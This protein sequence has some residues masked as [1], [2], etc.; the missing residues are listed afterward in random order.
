MRNTFL[1][2]ILILECVR[3][4]L[5]WGIAVHQPNPSVT[6][7]KYMIQ[8]LPLY[9]GLALQ[10]SLAV[11]I[12]FG[13]AKISRSRELDALHALGFS[14]VQLLTPII[15][16]T[17]AVIASSLIILGWLQP[18]SLY[19]SKVFVHD[20]EQ[21]S[22]LISDGADLFRVD[23]AKTL[24]LDGVSRD[25]KL[26]DR[27]FI[28]ETYPDQKS[29]TTTGTNGNIYGQGNLV[30]QQYFVNA[31]DL[32][33]VKRDALG[34]LASASTS[35]RSINVQGPL[36]D[37]GIKA[38]RPRGESEYEWTLSE[39]FS[40]GSNLAAS[41]NPKRLNAE[42]NYRLA[43]LLFIL[44]LPLIAVAAVIEPRRNPGPLRFLIGLLVVLGANQ[45]LGLATSFSRDDI[46]PPVLTLWIPLLL[47]AGV[48]FFRFWQIAY[49]PAFQGAR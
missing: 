6:I 18:L 15:A 8:W 16:L 20:I 24:M 49:K 22:A 9:I 26:F 27:V 30:S 46:L 14:L 37:I 1:Y 7:F 31:L 47:L 44:L 40:G 34:K 17:V 35:S 25:G 42:I 11:G 43:Q 41:V 29:V 21:S 23:G 3:L 48:V 5:I 4:K 39:L 13:L 28:F 45:Y 2:V 12:M 38:F 32:M 36:K 19:N 10:I 33:E